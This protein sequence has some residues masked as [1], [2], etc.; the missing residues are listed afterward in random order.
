MP[1]KHASAFPLRPGV[2]GSTVSAEALSP[3]RPT[4]DRTDFYIDVDVEPV[5]TAGSCGPVGRRPGNPCGV[6]RYLLGPVTFRPSSSTR[7]LTSA[8][9]PGF[10]GPRIARCTG[11]LRPQHR[12]PRAAPTHRCLERRRSAYPQ[13]RRLVM[14]RGRRGRDGRRR[15]RDRHPASVPSARSRPHQ[16]QATPAKEQDTVVLG[17]FSHRCWR[18]RDDVMDRGS[19]YETGERVTLRP[20]DTGGDITPIDTANAL[21]YAQPAQLPRRQL[22]AKCRRARLGLET[23]HGH[24][25]DVPGHHDHLHG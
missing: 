17:Q 23:V 24:P 20:N 19:T 13:H 4:C 5:T 11:G 12:L 9:P 7:W 3:P 2:C 1:R 21:D 8:G 22:R 10:R 14:C 15:T 6:S 25:H 16:R 18:L